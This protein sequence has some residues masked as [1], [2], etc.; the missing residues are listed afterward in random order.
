[1]A[2]ATIPLALPFKIMMRNFNEKYDAYMKANNYVNSVIVEYVEGIEVVKAFNQ[3]AFLM[4][5]LL[6]LLILLKNLR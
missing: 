2:L 4:G 3:T 5:N 1:M 6:K